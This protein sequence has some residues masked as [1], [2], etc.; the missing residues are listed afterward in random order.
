M[1]ADGKRDI[2]DVSFFAADGLNKSFYIVCESDQDITGDTGCSLTKF[3]TTSPFHDFQAV[4]GTSA[5]APAFA[6]VMA[7]V[8]QKTGQR[9][10]N[11][12]FVL[13]SLAKNET[14][15][16]CNSSNFT[17]PGTAL[18]GTCVFLDVTK[19]NNAVPC[20]GASTNCSKT[21][22]GGN[23]VLESNNNPA[24][25]AV[26]GYDLATGLGSINV[27]ALL[28]K[29]VV[30]ATNTATTTLTSPASITI[31]L[32][33]QQTISG[34]VTGAPGTPTGMVVIENSVTGAPID[35]A[36]LS[37]NNFTLN[38][39]LLPAGTYNIKAHYGGDG[40]F[41]ASDSTN[42]IPVSIGKQNA[43]V[44]V[45]FV[46]F[47]NTNPPQPILSTGAQS[48][49]YGSPY[50]L[51]VDVANNAGTTC[52]NVAAGTV[53]FICPTGAVALLDNNVALKDFPNAQT[54]GQSNI[55]TLN[56]RGFI[57]DQPIQLGVGSHPITATYTA[58]ANSSYISSTTTNTLSVTITQAATTTAVVGSPSIIT[59]G[60]SVT[61][62]ATVSSNSNSAQGPTGTIQFQNGST[63]IG[64]PVT[65]TPKGATATG[66]ASCT[67]T[68]STTLSALPPF[69]FDTPVRR[70]PFEWLAALLAV[71]AVLLCV[72]MMRARGTRRAYGYAAI[73]LFFAATAVL[74]GCSGGSGGGGNSHTDTIT[75]KYTGDTNYAA[76]Q[77]TGSVTVQ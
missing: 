3:V 53:N 67:A 30:P 23:G 29:W 72:M 34:T 8:N 54:P 44:I 58:D 47:T 15:A 69:T 14:F 75:A 40:A 46:T 18:P 52:E 35:T 49:P 24:F 6:G 68:L 42:T 76:S 20:V 32:G 16:S 56:N 22:A 37:G 41:G 10:G 26:A 59:A 38:T 21:T 5:S 33:T 55:A 27:N 9:Q 64:A 71:L 19:S 43:K 13:Y 60:A 45:S 66:G 73:A 31:T 50:I 62:T 2:P 28:T 77:G 36:T 57:E 74:A 17:N 63:N 48:V 4:G 51:R 61:L 1:P 39:T 25:N 11:P 70:T 7:L 65:C 12:N